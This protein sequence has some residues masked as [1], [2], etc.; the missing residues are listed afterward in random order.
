ML[1]PFQLYVNKQMPTQSSLAAGVIQTA[2]RLSVAVGLA[3]T[4]AVYSSIQRTPDGTNDT[5]F[6]YTRV[7]IC[8]VAF[9]SVGLL[10]IPF[11]RLEMQGGTNSVSSSMGT[12][13]FFDQEAQEVSPR[14]ASEYRVRV[15]GENS[16]SL[17]SKPS[18]SS[19]GTVATFGSE[20]TYFQRWS[21][22]DDPYWP[23]K[24]AERNGHSKSSNVVYEVCIKCL[25][26]R[27]VILPVKTSDD[28]GHNHDSPVMDGR[29]GW[30]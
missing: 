19:L 7:Y 13:P 17:A 28:E 16:S 24:P 21:W 6:P 12:E 25:E 11:M 14:A 30:I 3:I 20:A 23:P 1:I 26:E 27:R 2:Y 15:S 9:A 10:F 29:D 22:E 18:E 5:T 4:S 8:G